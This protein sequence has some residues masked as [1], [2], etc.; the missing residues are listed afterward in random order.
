MR[1]LKH[2]LLEAENRIDYAMFPFSHEILMILTYVIIDHQSFHTF[3]HKFCQVSLGSSAPFGNGAVSVLACV[4]RCQ[5][6]STILGEAERG[7][8]IVPLKIAA[9]DVII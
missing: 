1:F 8:K 7:D 3:F 5:G 2:L 6:S 9:I 4:R